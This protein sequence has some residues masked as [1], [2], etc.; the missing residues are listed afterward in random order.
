MKK[1]NNVL[2]LTSSGGSGL[3]NAAKAQKQAILKKDPNSKVIIKDI[4]LSDSWNLIGKFG[5]N[6]WNSSQK[7]GMIFWQKVLGKWKSIAEYLFWPQVFLEVSYLLEKEKIDRV[8]DTQVLSSSATLLAIKRYN[9][10]YKKSIV[11]EK[12][13]VD[14]PSY[15]NTL[16]FRP[17]K[18]LSLSQ[19][20]ALKLI[21]IK[22]FLENEKTL[23]E[24]WQTHCGMDES[25]VIYTDFPIRQG[26][27][28]YI[29]KNK[30]NLPFEILL[31]IPE[32]FENKLI[33][34]CLKNSL[35]KH[36]RTD[37]DFL[38]TIFPK[39]FLF[40]IVLGSQPTDQSTIKYIKSYIEIA[41]SCPEKKI[42]LFVFSSSWKSSRSL[43]QKVHDIAISH[44]IKNLSVI[45]FSLQEEDV[46]A[47]LF[48]RA[49]GTI[50][51]SAGQ[52]VLELMATCPK[53]RY[54]HSEAKP[55]QS[56]FDGMPGWE[57]G[58]AR[59]I[60]EKFGA[61]IVSPDTFSEQFSF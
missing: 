49:D 23:S 31:R 21:S 22:P 35:I 17:I 33:T 30:P 40:A 16:F 2:I 59:Y 48:F 57:A 47:K 53:K 3:L 10:K 36:T 24:F 13:I 11:L 54:I 43:F 14:I 5:V 8:I 28:G 15:Q 27:H 32:P 52:T 55:H 42:H 4:L 37:K 39:E 9:K 50:T 51:R 61:V 34:D 19:K 18:K 25:S 29:G 7:Y 56:I 58:G 60:R 1:T 45:P 6:I 12:V 26:F 46:I 20:K 44:S 38:F 41:K